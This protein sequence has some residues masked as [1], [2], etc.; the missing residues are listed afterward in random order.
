MIRVTSEAEV[1][2]LPIDLWTMR[3]AA[4]RPLAGCVESLSSEELDRLRNQLRGHLHV[5]APAVETAASR[6]PLGDEARRR[7][8]ACS[9]LAHQALRLGR[10]DTNLVRVSVV[11]KLAHSVR[12]L[13]RHWEA[14]GGA[15]VSAAPDRRGTARL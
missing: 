6:L 10:G 7:A 14:L 13:S 11:E 4:A 8:R 1:D 12:N 9:T 5:L 15:S 3:E 2:A